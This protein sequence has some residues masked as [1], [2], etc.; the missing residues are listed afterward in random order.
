M[1]DYILSVVDT[2]FLS[3][4]F[5][6]VSLF[7]IIFLNNMIHILIW[8]ILL[9]AVSTLFFISLGSIFISL[10]FFIVYISGISLI[11]L[12]V[13]MSFE[14]DKDKMTTTYTLITVLM[15]LFSLLFFSSIFYS[16]DF[17]N[18]SEDS[19]IFTQESKNHSSD[20]FKIAYLLYNSQY[21]NS[22]I[23]FMFFLLLSMVV[24]IDLTNYRRSYVMTLIQTAQ[25][26][27][28]NN[29]NILTIYKIRND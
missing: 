10:I 20:I 12:F 26:Y 11:F 1:I 2:T 17:N 7:S 23:F 24:S 18:L 28:K 3:Y 25:T 13:I 8:I 5:I 19:I 4:L 22:F 6:L 21:I 15:I 14:L 29:Y 27:R 16:I 9:F